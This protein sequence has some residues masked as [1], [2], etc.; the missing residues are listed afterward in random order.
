MKW[1]DEEID[2]IAKEAA[3]NVEVPYQD[4]YWA[5]MEA[6][7]PAKSNKRAF[8][9]IFRILFAFIGLASF[10]AVFFPREVDGSRQ[11]AAK[12][13]QAIELN[14]DLTIQDRQDRNKLDSKMN[15]E[16][17]IVDEDLRSE[18]N[19]KTDDKIISNTNLENQNSQHQNLNQSTS[20]KS[21][22]STSKVE[23]QNVKTS[24]LD[25]KEIQRNSQ[26]ELSVLKSDQFAKNKLKD[27]SLNNS[28]YHPNSHKMIMED[29]LKIQEKNTIS[30][31][32][33]QIAKAVKKNLPIDSV[34]LDDQNQIE[35]QSTTELDKVKIVERIPNSSYYVQ[36]GV[37][38]SQSYLKTPSNQLMTGLNIGIGYQYMKSTIG[39]SVGIHATSSFVNNMEIVRKSRVYGFGVVNYQQN[40]KYKQLTYLELPVN[41]IYRKNQNI[42]SI[43]LAPTYLVSTMMN[44]SE[45]SDLETLNERNYYGQKI[46]LKSIGLESM[47]GYQR[48]L[49]NNWSVGVQVGVTLIQQVQQNYFENKT[50]AFPINGQV[51]IRKTLIPKR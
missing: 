50:V 47:L 4:S 17:Q 43:G 36:A 30:N 11:I 16:N 38:F 51:T 27:Q 39:Y 6:L 3:G 13:G 2:K 18:I 34:A 24:G 44:F 32:E 46:G 7:L 45:T 26:K 8:W 33:N 40:L 29:S 35:N 22:I 20:V 48:C 10:F 25:K 9:W 37:K 12:N 28:K 21:P 49:K 1:T 5:E 41:L 15:L 42:F 31:E 14:D 23:N 19:S